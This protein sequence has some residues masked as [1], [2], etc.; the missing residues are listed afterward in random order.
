M[1]GVCMAR[2]HGRGACVAGQAC[3]F[4]GMHSGGHEWQGACMA[5]GEACMAGEMATAAD[6]THSTGMH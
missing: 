5:R 4:G 3:M 6:S 2:G 1:A